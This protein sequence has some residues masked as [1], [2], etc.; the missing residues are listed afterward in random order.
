MPK[1]KKIDG[2]KKVVT[3]INGER[4]IIYPSYSA[5]IY[6]GDNPI[7][8]SLCHTLLGWEEETDTNKFGTEF[9]FT[10]LDGR[11]IRCTNDVRNRPL[12]MNTL[13]TTY[14]YEI[15]RRKFRYNGETI[16]IGQTGIVCNGQHQLLA[17][18]LAIQEWRKNPDK[19]PQWDC[20]PFIEKLVAFGIHEDDETINTMDTCKP[21]SLMEVIFRSELLKTIKGAGRKAAC[22]MLDYGIRG[23]WDRTGAK[24]NAYAPIRTHSESLDFLSRHP[25]LVEC[26]KHIYEETK[27]NEEKI[28]WVKPGMATALMYLMAS[29][30]T[31]RTAYYKSES[32]NESLLQM[33]NWDKACDFWSILNDNS[34]D[35]LPVRNKIQELMAQ[36][37]G[38]ASERIAIVV[39][40]W[41][42]FV[43][44]EV[45]LYDD[46][47]LRYTEDENGFLC[48]AELPTVGGIDIGKAGGLNEPEPTST[49]VPPPSSNTSGKTNGHAVPSLGIKGKKKVAPKVETNDTVYVSEDG[50]YWVGELVETYQVKEKTFARVKNSRGKFFDTDIHNISATEPL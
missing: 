41:N 16:I 13:V 29:S 46:L 3:T 20:E 27:E 22:S 48:L 31:D 49:D 1:V 25:K 28:Q 24:E 5:T 43:T 50:G 38:N 36:G 21:R 30:N 45:V 40:A 10:D 19:Y 32:P 39:K 17:L 8:E 47:D 26:V 23:L 37:Y 35:L 12:Y 18:A 4:E 2:L 11:K 9:L 33:S 15:L 7:T 42:V 44:G 34:D 6:A 14:M